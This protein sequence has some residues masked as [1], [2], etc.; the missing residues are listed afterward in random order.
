MTP[1][2]EIPDAA[3]F[4]C[5][6]R[7]LVS[8]VAERGGCDALIFDAPYSDRTHSSHDAGMT[9]ANKKTFAETNLG[10]PGLTRE[11]RAEARYA[12]TDRRRSLNYDHWTPEDVAEFVTAWLPVN[13][14]WWVSL[15]DHVLAQAWEAEFQ[16]AGLYTFS[17]IAC[18]ESGSRVRMSGDGPAQWSCWAI[19]ARPR[20]G[21]WNKW[22]ALPGAY[23]V[24]EGQRGEWR[25]AYGGKRVVGGKPR[26][27][28]E[29]LCEDYSRPGALVC[30]PVA[31]GFTTGSAAL[32][33]GRRFIGGDAL[34]E[35][36][37]LGAS[38]ARGKIQRPMLT[39]IVDPVVQEVMFR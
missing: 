27:L 21:G 35:H 17:P 30:D 38:W 37:E 1:L 24:P 11:E 22:G 36:A 2:V 6:W 4:H 7:E 15:T 12:L 29:R 18:V 13:Q 5:D 34:Q 28:M 23:V 32:A 39:R 31:G 19:V 33:T 10:S 9:L 14:G 20:T 3:V 25:N 26:W 8:V 16:R